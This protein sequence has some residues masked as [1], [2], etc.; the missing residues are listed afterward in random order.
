LHGE[1]ENDSPLG[2]NT[3][4]GRF[5][6]AVGS[7]YGLGVKLEWGSLKFRAWGRGRAW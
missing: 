6:T 1:L 4:R 3:G 5:P 2:R 7:F